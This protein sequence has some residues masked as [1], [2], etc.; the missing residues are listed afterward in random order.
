MGACQGVGSACARTLEYGREQQRSDQPWNVQT[1]SCGNHHEGIASS[2][3]R[4]S[5]VQTAWV[6]AC[7]V[8]PYECGALRA[9]RTR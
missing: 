9:Q 2:L 4:N 8:L 7:E 6:P 3:L 1:W 5:G